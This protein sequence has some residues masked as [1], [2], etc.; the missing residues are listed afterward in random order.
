M[1]TLHAVCNLP[2]MVVFL[3]FLMELCAIKL[4]V[5]TY[6]HNQRAGNHN[7]AFASAAVLAKQAHC[8]SLQLPFSQHWAMSVAAKLLDPQ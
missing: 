6:S 8:Q 2:V 5:V 3:P 4:S 7:I 1:F